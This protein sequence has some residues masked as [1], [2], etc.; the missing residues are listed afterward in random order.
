MKLVWC[1]EMASKAYIDGVKTLAERELADTDVAEL[2]SAMAGGW[3][4]QLIVEAPAPAPHDVAAITLALSA[5]ARHTGARYVCVYPDRNSAAEHPAEVVVGEAAEAMGGLE[6]V[7]LLV[8]DARR[9]DAAAAVAA[10]RPGPRGM[11][12]VQHHA[13]RRRGCGGGGVALVPAVDSARGS[14]HGRG[15]RVPTL[16]SFWIIF[17]SYVN[18]PAQQQNLSPNTDIS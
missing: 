15:A 9:G 3:N 7:D 5:A 1:P 8:V 6:G 11:V 2:V 13:G 17:M 12:V 18:M 4:A 14:G 16:I 10:A